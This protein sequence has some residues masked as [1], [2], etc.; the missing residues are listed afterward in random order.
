MIIFL[1]VNDF[2]PKKDENGTTKDFKKA[3][4]ILKV[5]FNEK[6]AANHNSMTWETKSHEDGLIRK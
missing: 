4:L 5:F 1:K 6:S 3:P 2:F